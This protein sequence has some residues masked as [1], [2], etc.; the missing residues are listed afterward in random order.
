MVE[1]PHNDRLYC[2]SC[3]QIIEFSDEELVRQQE[4]VLKKHR[5]HAV[6]LSYQIFGYCDRC[7]SVR[8]DK[9]GRSSPM[10]R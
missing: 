2:I 8:A 7:K 9:L 3:S 1:T 4:L 5:F 10:Q 6:Y